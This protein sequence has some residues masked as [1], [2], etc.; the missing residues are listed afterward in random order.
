KEQSK[1]YRVKV[2]RFRKSVFEYKSLD[3]ANKSN[4][5]IVEINSFANPFPFRPLIIKSFAHDFLIETDNE[6]LIKKYTLQPFQ[7]N[8]LDKEQTLLEKLVSLIR[9]SFDADPKTSIASKIRH[10]YSIAL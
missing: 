3:P 1:V 7:V 9:F 6:A 2:Q 10:F 5:L 4:T 8:V